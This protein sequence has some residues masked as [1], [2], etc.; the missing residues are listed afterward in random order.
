[1]DYLLYNE[2]GD[3][4]WESFLNKAGYA[5]QS[6]RPLFLW[7]GRLED[8]EHTLHRRNDEVIYDS[9]GAACDP[10]VSSD[11]NTLHYYKAIAIAVLFHKQTTVPEFRT[12]FFLDADI[13]FTD[14]AFERMSNATNK[15]SYT[16]GPEDYFDISPQASLWGSQN[17]AGQ[18][19]MNGGLLGLKNT[20]WLHDFSAL[21][22]F[23]RCGHKDQ[24]GLWL[25]LF[26]TWSANTASDLHSW[27]RDPVMEEGRQF[28]Y[29]GKALDVYHFAVVLYQQKSVSLIMS[30]LC[31]RFR[32]PS[33]E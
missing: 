14:E 32:N 24:R 16:F 19:V 8:E 30:V 2:R 15:E 27:T 13:S 21:W 25:V 29:P 12:A 33:K 7:L 5:Y 6:Q 3:F 22:W 28:S 9:F 10:D 1:L 17:T 4:A 31:F 18:I 26:A 11:R 20:T 23:S